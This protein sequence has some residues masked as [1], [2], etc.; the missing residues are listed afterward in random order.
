MSLLNV[1]RADYYNA[2]KDPRA[3]IEESAGQDMILA[4]DFVDA[5]ERVERAMSERP[6]EFQLKAITFMGQSHAPATRQFERG[7]LWS[8]QID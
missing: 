4:T 1:Y 6:I 2:A 8:P 5:L 3:E 7:S